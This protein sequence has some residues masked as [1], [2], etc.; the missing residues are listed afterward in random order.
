MF[1]I[2]QKVV[3]VESG[4]RTSGEDSGLKKGE[5]YPVIAIVSC[6]CDVNNQFIHIGVPTFSDT[7]RI[8]CRY[9]DFGLP[10]EIEYYRSKRFRP[11]DEAFGENVA[12]AIEEQFKFQEA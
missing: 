3:C 5:I 7:L 4:G 8:R 9:C 11:I 6:R 12:A 1:R 10:K 2:G